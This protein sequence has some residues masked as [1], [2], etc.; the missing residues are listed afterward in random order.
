MLHL[1]FQNL[2]KKEAYLLASLRVWGDGTVKDPAGGDPMQL[3]LVYW[4]AVL[5]LCSYNIM[6][7]PVLPE[8]QMLN[9]ILLIQEEDTISHF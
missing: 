8:E 7:I 4:S 2:T 5:G 1:N 3:S 6:G 9:R